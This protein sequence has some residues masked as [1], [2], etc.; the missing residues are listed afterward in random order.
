[1]IFKSKLTVIIKFSLN[2]TTTKDCCHNDSEFKSSVTM[3]KR[4]RKKV[5]LVHLL[6]GLDPSLLLQGPE[7]L[8]NLSKNYLS[9]KWGLGGF[10][11]P[12]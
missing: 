3:T 4:H 6:E 11:N 5:C 2:K 12:S 8:I 1:M 7:L 9:R 10:G